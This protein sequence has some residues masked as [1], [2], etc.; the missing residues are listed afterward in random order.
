MKRN[1]AVTLCV[2]L[3]LMILL[4]CSLTSLGL[5][6]SKDQ[7]PDT[8][9]ENDGGGEINL[10]SN[11]PVTGE[12]LCANAYFPVRQGATWEYK[13]TST[14]TDPY[15]YTDMVTEVREDGF[16]LTGQFNEVARVQEWECKPEGL[17][18]LQIGG[19]PAGA[20]YAQNLKTELQIQNANGLTIPVAINPGDTWDHGLDFT[21]VV[22]LPTGQ[23]AEASGNAQ[24]D[25]QAIGVE[26]VSVP[27]GTFD[28]MKVDSTMTINI[29][30]T[31]SGFTV[32]ITFSGNSSSW[33]V[34]GVGFVKSVSESSLNGENFTDTVELQSYSI[35]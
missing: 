34:Q 11:M 28:A 13:G 27:A 23:S 20:V 26:S 6:Q 2:L 32:P 10:G 14:L 29:N 31:V 30:A 16:T 33:Y 7:N 19:G 4:A 21:G 24:I 15:S 1:F 12:G 25:F 35:P 9:S 5:D 22:N 8:N 18:S 3:S 17:V